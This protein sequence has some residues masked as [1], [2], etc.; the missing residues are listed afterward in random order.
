MKKF[1]FRPSVSKP[2]LNMRVAI[3]AILLVGLVSATWVGQPPIALSFPSVEG[4]TFLDA[5]TSNPLLFEGATLQPTLTLASL[6][7]FLGIPAGASPSSFNGTI[8]DGVTI[9]LDRSTPGAIGN[10]NFLDKAGL[11]ASSNAIPLA[12]GN[13]V[14]AQTFSSKLGAWVVVQL[15]SGVVQ[16]T[17]LAQI[18]DL[19]SSIE[20]NNSAKGQIPGSV[21]LLNGGLPLVTSSANGKAIG[22]LSFRP[23]LVAASTNDLWVLG[24][25]SS[26]PALYRAGNSGQVRGLLLPKDASNGVIA[27]TQNSNCALL[28]TGVG[29]KAFSE[30][31]AIGSPPISQ[32]DIAGVANGVITP[33]QSSGQIQ[34]FLYQTGGLTK[35]ASVHVDSGCALSNLK[36]VTVMAIRMSSQIIGA[37]QWRNYLVTISNQPGEAFQVVS[38]GSGRAVPIQGQMAP[39]SFKGAAPGIRNNLQFA[40]YAQGFVLNDP[41]STNVAVVKSV[42]S[43]LKLSWIARSSVYSYDAQS[44]NSIH[45]AAPKAQKSPKQSVIQIR[46]SAKCANVEPTQKVEGLS[47]TSVLAT[48]AT[49]QFTVPNEGACVAGAFEA[50]VQQTNTGQTVSQDCINPIPLSSGDFQCTLTGLSRLTTYQVQIADKWGNGAVADATKSD[51][52]SITTINVDLAEP[53]SVQAAYDKQ[54]Q[55]WNVTW[56]GAQGKSTVWQVTV[57]ACPDQ[58]IA[59]YSPP[60]QLTSH[61]FG[62]LAIPLTSNTTLFGQNLEFEVAPGVVIGGITDYA[63]PTNWTKCQWTPP[64]LACASNGGIQISGSVPDNASSGSEATINLSSTIGSQCF[65]GQA[66]IYYRYSVISLGTPTWQDCIPGVAWHPDYS[67]MGNNYPSVCL[68]NASA[69][70]IKSGNSQVRARFQ[71]YLPN[72][73]A[74]DDTSPGQRVAAGSLSNFSWPSAGAVHANFTY[75]PNSSGNVNSLGNLVVGLNGLVNSNEATPPFSIPNVPVLACTGEDGQQPQVDIGSINY[76]YSNI[77]G[78]PTVT[79]SDAGGNN[80][81]LIQA[82]GGMC[83]LTLELSI[84]AI[85]GGA[86]VA[87][88]LDNAP[89]IIDAQQELVTPGFG[90]VPNPSWFGICTSGHTVVLSI[91]PNSACQSNSSTVS[92]GAI[93]AQDTSGIFVT[94]NGQQE[95]LV[96]L[97]SWSG[98]GPPPTTY[99]FT[100]SMLLGSAGVSLTFQWTYLDTNTQVT[101]SN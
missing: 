50:F 68:V 79:I 51:P 31:Q 44:A 23:G 41:G 66:E 9:L 25:Q 90:W 71:V 99:T 100:S 24:K 39:Q 22:G 74:L 87:T 62:H 37:W 16:A 18:N 42:G 27:S 17:H 55:I 73:L 98:T 59:P 61:S 69:A 26:Q 53:K 33:V 8:S 48:S 19:V 11:V 82:T 72:G 64:S 40:G 77:G 95:M 85:G 38:L 65:L 76:S 67:N 6:Q 56:S 101:V 78:V 92:P 29:I 96:P 75:V 21:K 89:V 81:D 47:L 4:T 57:N 93:T 43:S 84:P 7:K 54:N 10:L 32:V 88:V 70:S 60:I 12:N 63:P 45:S 94:Y 30:R 13:A 91:D 28:A 83:T 34:T 20:Q 52:I 3:F 97:Q 80:F 15:Q 86:S 2:I 49:L 35:F 46:A 1:S 36:V 14:A 5:Q 58:T